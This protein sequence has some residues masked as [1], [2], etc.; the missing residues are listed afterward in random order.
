MA[1]QILD[2]FANLCQSMGARLEMCFTNPDKNEIF[3]IQN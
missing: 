2:D 3:C 1:K